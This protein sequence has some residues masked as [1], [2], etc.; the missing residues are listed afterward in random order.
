LRKRFG[1]TLSS[2]ENGLNAEGENT[3]PNLQT[4]DMIATSGAG[5]TIS[6]LMLADRL[7]TLAQD[8]DRAGFAKPA[9]RM[10][11]LAYA[12]WNEKPH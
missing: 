6:P 7:L 9:E 11:R 5:E 12:V 4:L 2:S 1:A 10:L 3:M 8:A